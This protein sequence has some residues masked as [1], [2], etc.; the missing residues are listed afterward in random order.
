MKKALLLFALTACD[1]P[2]DTD[3]SIPCASTQITKATQDLCEEYREL[4][5]IALGELHK[6]DGLTHAETSDFLEINC[7]MSPAEIAHTIETKL[8]LST[9]ELCVIR[10]PI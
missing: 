6:V 8:D 10:P 5:I 1:K 7:A 2:L 9:A 4:T 3:I